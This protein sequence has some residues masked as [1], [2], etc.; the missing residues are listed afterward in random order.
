[1]T[2]A[3]PT[4]SSER[5]RKSRAEAS[6]WVV[7][8]HGPERSAALEAAFRDWL[9]SDPQHQHEFERVTRVWV[10]APQIPLG[11]ATRLVQ[12]NQPRT[13]WRWAIAAAVL[14]ICGIGTFGVYQ[15]WFAGV[16]KTDVG[17]QRIVRLE[18]GTR[19]S[20]NSDTRVEVWFANTQRHVRLERGEAYFEVAHNPQRPFIVTAG[21]HDV[22]AVGT[23]FMVRYDDGNTAV[24]LVEGKVTVSHAVVEENAAAKDETVASTERR[25]ATRMGEK[26][27]EPRSLAR[28]PALSGSAESGAPPP[29]GSEVHHT[30]ADAQ[31]SA[32]QVVT[33][34]PGERLVLLSNAAATLDEPHIDAVTAWRR[35]EVVLE[36]TRLDAAVTEM[37]RYEERKLV[38]SSPEIAH[39]E[40]SGIYHVGDGAGF[41]D[42]IAT[43]YHL[44]LRSTKDEISIAAPA[45][46][47]LWPLARP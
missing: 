4:T 42:T 37:N 6:A 11:G 44:Q 41:A 39:L 33:L 28:S 43:L 32:Q 23:A 10:E 38:I 36:H 5:R 46:R 26:R 47:D 9:A 14:L 35:G 16:Y 40:I 7:K 18:D 45:R 15:V 19:V 31:A 1:M 25:D 24:T 20:L 34:S 3:T 22:T 13:A 21:N 2:S 27:G 30:T 12:W 8:L 29:V 17:E